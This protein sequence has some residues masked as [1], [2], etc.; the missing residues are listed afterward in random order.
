MADASCALA[1]RRGLKVAREIQSSRLTGGILMECA[2]SSRE[3]IACWNISVTTSVS[4]SIDYE[5]E[6]VRDLLVGRVGSNNVRKA[7]IWRGASCVEVILKKLNVV[8]LAPVLLRAREHSDVA[9]RPHVYLTLFF[10]T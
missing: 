3:S 1:L 10:N 7:K 5:I 9:A 8:V 4:L 6:M 2:G